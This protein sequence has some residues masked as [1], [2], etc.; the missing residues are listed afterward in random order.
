[1]TDHGSLD[2]ATVAAMVPAWTGSGRR[3]RV[4]AAAPDGA[5]E[6]ALVVQNMTSVADLDD[7]CLL[8]DG[9]LDAAG[10][11]AT[12]SGGW[13]AAGDEVAVWDAGDQRVTVSRASFV[14]LLRRLLAL[15]IEHERDAAL[16]VDERTWATIRTRIEEL[17]GP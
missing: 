2:D 11:R 10:T 7:L 16:D 5:P 17:A 12:D 13:S 3:A 9:A 15:A 6:G 4:R 8:A 1:V 14:D